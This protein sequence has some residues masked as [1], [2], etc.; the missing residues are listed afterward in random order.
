MR[1][2][3]EQRLV[4]VLDHIYDHP[5]GDLSL[6][7]LAD[8]AAMSRFHWHRVFLA[9]TGETTA[10]AVRRIR[11]HRAAME[12][13]HTDRPLAEIAGRVGYPN[14]PSFTRAFT[15]RWGQPPAAFR[16]T[17]RPERPAPTFRTG[18]ALMHPVEIRTCPPLTLAA[19]PHR[20]AYN[21][22][23]RAFEKLGTIF[24]ARGLFPQVRGMVGVY[25]DSPAETPAADLRSHAGYVVAE[26]LAFDPP[27]EIV[28][29]A[30][31]RHAVLTHKGPYTAL[32]AAYDQL[33]CVWLPESGEEAASR[34]AYEVY[35]NTPMDTAPEDLVTEIH[36]PLA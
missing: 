17:G 28:R 35:L 12:L 2:D 10:D 8:V 32:A 21:D 7:A 33:F 6:D 5:A 27:I 19:L 29:L 11:L 4:R 14:V 22:I 16:Q 9:M 26:G 24:A 36:L 23:S 13:V 31:G 3:Y 1:S 34:P 30:P 20:G 25:Y 15:A 18:V